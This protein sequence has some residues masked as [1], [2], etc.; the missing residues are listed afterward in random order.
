LNLASDPSVTSLHEINLRLAVLHNFYCIH[1]YYT[2][3]SV[4]G[5]Q[6]KEIIPQMEKIRGVLDGKLVNSV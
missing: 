4:A 3:T 2:R 6:W 5:N 1:V